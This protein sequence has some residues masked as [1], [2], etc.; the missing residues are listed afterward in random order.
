[1]QVVL[2]LPASELEG[3]QPGR[4]DFDFKQPDPAELFVTVPIDKYRNEARS[5]RGAD[6]FRYFYTHP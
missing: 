6:L 1:M 5:L 4:V 3:P 2:G